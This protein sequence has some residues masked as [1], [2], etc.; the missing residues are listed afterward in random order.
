MTLKETS[1]KVVEMSA[2]VNNNSSFQNYINL[3]D[4]I[5]QTKNTISLLY[6]ML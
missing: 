2:I 5:Q 6:I 3:D 1:A 4:H